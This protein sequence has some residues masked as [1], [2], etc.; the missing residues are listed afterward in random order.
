MRAKSLAVVLLFLVAQAGANDTEDRQKLQS[1]YDQACEEVRSEKLAVEKVALIEECVNNE[2]WTKDRDGCE[3]F[4][5]DHG[6]IAAKYYDLPECV[7]AFE[8]KKS[9]RQ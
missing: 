9:Y 8:Y 7:K 6:A 4:Y 1:T 2:S 5:Q 3:R